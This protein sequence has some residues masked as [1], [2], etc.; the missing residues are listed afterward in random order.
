M[1]SMAIPPLLV[2][3]VVL[4]VAPA[5]RA[6]EESDKKPAPARAAAVRSLLE[7]ATDRGVPLFNAGQVAAC[8]AVYEVAA[9]GALAAGADLT[10]DERKTLRDALAFSRRA[11][12]REGAWILRGAFD[13]VLASLGRPTSPAKKEVEYVREAEL[14][15]GFPAPGP[16][17]EVVVKDYPKYRAARAEGGRFAFG[18]L[19]VHIKSN[20]IAMTAPVEMAMDEAASGGMAMKSMAF[21]YASP[22]LGQVGRDGRVEVLDLP[23]QRV[24]SYGM[25]GPVTADKIAAA[26]RAIEARRKIDGSNRDGDWRLM[27]YNSPMV[28]EAKRFYELQLPVAAASKS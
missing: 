12:A 21:L 8:A 19:F 1:K 23:P 14:P 28:P 6:G 17:G 10:D 9:T 7:L 11:D 27:G 25:F 18:T 24:L 2:A 20:E 15:R 13:R 22:D 26:R 5:S 4:V 16:V 3:V